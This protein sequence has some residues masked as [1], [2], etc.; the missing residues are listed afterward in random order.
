MGGEARGAMTFFVFLLLK[1][2]E[3]LMLCL[4]CD[5]CNISIHTFDL[6][7]IFQKTNLIMTGRG[8]VD[9]EI[10]FII[11][12]CQAL[13]HLRLNFTGLLSSQINFVQYCKKIFF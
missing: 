8:N 11:L 7:D 2:K 9:T 6:I 1:S 13:A 12:I 4:S 5:F 3:D 10:V